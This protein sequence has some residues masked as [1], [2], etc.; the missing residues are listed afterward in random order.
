VYSDISPEEWERELRRQ[1]LP[2]HL[3]GPGGSL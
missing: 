3:T 2:E 1:G